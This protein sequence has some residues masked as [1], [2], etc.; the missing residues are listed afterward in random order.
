MKRLVFYIGMIFIAFFLQTGVF[1]H[2]SLGGIVPN[3]FIICTTTIGII[4]GKKE[5][6]L[7]GFF[8]GIL[9]DALFAKYFGF[10]GLIYALIGY[11]AGYVNQIFYEEDMTLPI[12]IIGVGDMLYGIAIY[13]CSFLTR[14]RM[15]FLFYLRKIIFPE[16]IYT[17]II[18]V[19][20]YRLICLI[21]RKIETKGSETRID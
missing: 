7:V 6:C 21:S 5:G 19:F 16:T 11:L 3:L 1:T 15:D 18:G 17:L 12:I 8:C 14:G 20:L 13:L 4:H 10:Y 9:M 2:L